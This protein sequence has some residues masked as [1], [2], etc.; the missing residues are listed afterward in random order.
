MSLFSCFSATFHKSNASY[1][2]G[3]FLEK[4]NVACSDSIDVTK[5]SMDIVESGF[6]LNKNWHTGVYCKRSNTESLIL[7]GLISGVDHYRYSPHK[8]TLIAALT[9]A[10]NRHNMG[11]VDYSCYAG[12]DFEMLDSAVEL[13]DAEIINKQLKE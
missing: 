6:S 4:A 11:E 3:A 12:M 10:V 2:V 9:I 5:C 13:L 8:E 1:Q 7:C